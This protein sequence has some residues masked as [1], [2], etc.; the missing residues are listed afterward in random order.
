MSL[1]AVEMKLI[2]A[3]GKG[4]Y[5]PLKKAYTGE[6]EVERSMGEINKLCTPHGI[7]A[8]LRHVE[9][10]GMR[11]PIRIKRQDRM[12]KCLGLMR[13]GRGE[14]W[15]KRGK[16][17]SKVRLSASPEKPATAKQQWEAH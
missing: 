6:H 13:E 3:T 11:Q 8:R 1:K 2:A 5:T 7:R 10:S 9:K 16:K 4:R 12:P 15:K 14:C 17:K